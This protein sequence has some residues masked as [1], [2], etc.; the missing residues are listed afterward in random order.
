MGC[1]IVF[2]GIE[3]CGKTTQISLLGEYLKKKGLPV[4]VTREPGGTPIGDE[5]RKILLS[6]N[7]AAIAPV[8]ELLLYTASKVQHLQQVIIPALQEG[9]IV[10]CDRFFDATIAYQGYG[11]GVDL[12]L[13]HQVHNSFL[14]DSTPDLTILLDC[15][16]ELGLG[17]SRRRIRQEGKESAEGRFEEKELVFHERVRTGYLKLAR[18]E[19][20]RFCIINGAQAVE[21][22]QQ[23]I[24]A[25]VERTLKERGYAI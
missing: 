2:E 21:A 16:A 19:P 18:M 15:P 22:T 1:F 11:E 25:A 23:E 20:E 3:G 5:I 7:N 17:R 4:I 9:S 12:T 14:A 10:L 8:T 13:V 6:A 24:Y